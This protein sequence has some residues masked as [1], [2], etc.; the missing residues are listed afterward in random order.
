M[1]SQIQPLEDALSSSQMWEKAQI[2]KRKCDVWYQ[3]TRMAE[4]NVDEIEKEYCYHEDLDFES[5]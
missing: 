5:R 1:A 4:E 2:E 3:L